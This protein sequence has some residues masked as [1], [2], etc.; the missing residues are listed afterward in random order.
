MRRPTLIDACTGAAA[1]VAEAAMLRIAAD[2]G[3][4]LQDQLLGVLPAA[5]FVIVGVLAAPRFPAVAWPSITIATFL[6]SVEVLAVVRARERLVTP[7]SWAELSW[8]AA[9]T[10]V[11]ATLV[12]AAYAGKDWRRSIASRLLGFLVL[13]AGLMAAAIVA[14]SA[15][16]PV[17]S[18]AAAS[19]TS[20]FRVAARIGVATIAAGLCIGLALDV[21]KPAHRA[22]RRWRTEGSPGSGPLWR[23]LGLFADEV[24]PGRAA[25]QRAAAEAERAR[26]AADLH[27]LV[28]PD[29]RRAAAAA[30]AA[31]VP[32]DAQ[33]DLRRALEDVEQLMHERQSVVLEQFGL[34]AALEWLAE[35]TQERSPI[36]VEV[37]LDGEVPDG[38]GVVE[39]RVARAAFRIAL[40]ALDNAV[41]HAGARTATV[42]LSARPETLRLEVVDDGTARAATARPA[43][44]RGL[45]DMRSE[46]S[47]SG[48]AIQVTLEPS[49]H[50]TT[51]WPRRGGTGAS[52]PRHP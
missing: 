15:S 40:L 5:A 48:G 35:R 37:E 26:L 32:A 12:A 2:T 44:G 49:V 6:G 22:F 24:L 50:V 1:I 4:S 29:L 52:Q 25:E 16:A 23:Y 9:V 18:A 19:G 21:A 3:A 7:D 42:R 36:R 45:A 47:T 39:P 27:A 43:A 28:L 46:A 38:P 31:G 20:P 11:V 33:V 51:E 14:V 8:V 30:E 10:L 41:R 13:G 34:V 17:D